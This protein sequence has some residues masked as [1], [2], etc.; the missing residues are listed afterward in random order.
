MRPLS[1]FAL[2][3]RA[4]SERVV[5]LDLLDHQDFVLQVDLA[6]SL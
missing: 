2:V 6:L 4:T 5:D 1:R 3:V